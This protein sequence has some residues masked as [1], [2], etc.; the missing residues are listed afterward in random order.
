MEPRIPQAEP[1]NGASLPAG[2]RFMQVQRRGSWHTRTED[3]CLSQVAQS[4]RSGKSKKVLHF[5]TLRA[6][7]ASTGVAY[8]LISRTGTLESFAAAP[9]IS[10]VQARRDW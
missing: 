4:P 6:D 1:G 2:V 10:F 8:L 5:L 9:V 3:N 7:N